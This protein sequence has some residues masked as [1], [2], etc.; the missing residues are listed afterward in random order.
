MAVVVSLKRQG[1]LLL[2]SLRSYVEPRTAMRLERLGELKNPMTLLGIEF[3]TFR[4]IAQ[5][6]NQLQY[7]MT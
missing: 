6:L 5:F 3:A 1:F 4:L 2:I 7:P